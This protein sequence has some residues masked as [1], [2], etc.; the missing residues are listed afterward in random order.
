MGKV[1]Q[2]AGAL[3]SKEREDRIHRA[4]VKKAE[5]PKIP[6]SVLSL[7]FGIPASTL[8][9][10]FNGRKNRQEAHQN[11]QKLSPVIEKSLKKWIQDM[12]DAGF[13]PRVDLLRGMASA[14]AQNI[15]EEDKLDPTAAIIGRNWVSR[16]LDRHP[17]LAAKYSTQLDRQ[18]QNASN[19]ITLRD[20]FNK[21]SRL[22]RRLISLGLWPSDDIYNFD[23]K[24]F[25]L[26]YSAKA[27]VICRSGRRNPNVAQDG[28]R[29]LITVVETVSVGG[30]AL[31]PWVIYKGKGHYMGW[32]Q[33]T[34]EANAV[35]AYSD[36]GWTDNNMGLRWLREHF[37]VYSSKISGTRPRLLHYYGKAADNHIRET[38][39]GITK[40]TFWSFF[41]EARAKAFTKQTIK[42]SFQATGIFPLNPDKVLTK[43]KPNQLT[44]IPVGSTILLQKQLSTPK[45]RRELRQQTHF[46]LHPEA[47]LKVGLAESKPI[48][49]QTDYSAIILRLSHLAEESLTQ[50]DI[51]K[52][53]LR[54]LRVK[55]EGKRAVRADRRV[56]S[57]AQVI[58][59]AE[60]I[61]L[62][63][64]LEKKEAAKELKKERSSNAL[65][66]KLLA[67]KE[68]EAR[69]SAKQ[70]SAP[71][72]RQPARPKKNM[73]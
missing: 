12:D 73:F 10:R 29:E 32:H 21:L 25:I 22:V 6:W 31:P 23:E 15:A 65:K 62:K 53:Q 11:Q 41:T 7:E 13:P 24:G 57:K 28:S 30:L 50:A 52:I 64:A 16:F 17:D 35:F 54:D 70:R 3:S 71:T 51:A 49:N 59:G 1:K 48:L 39:T 8:N 67:E 38:R 68:E 56:L 27:K 33:E 58:T 45:N 63:N 2:R 61:R 5:T 44:A 47:H 72:R 46:A 40:G 60:I 43:V 9:D 14:L 19:P 66:D 69:D 55:Y 20:Y 26:G 18:R 36:N 34:N 4:L 42:A 37:D